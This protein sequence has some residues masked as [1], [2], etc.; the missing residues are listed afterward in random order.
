MARARSRADG[1][2]PATAVARWRAARRDGRAGADHGRAARRALRRWCASP[3][4]APTGSSSRSSSIRRSSRRTR[5]SPPIRAP[6]RPTLRRWPR[7]TSTWSGRRDVAG[8]VSG[9]LCHP[10]RAGGPGRRPGSRMRSGRISS[11]GVATV[12]A[13]LFIQA[14]PD[15]AMFGEKDYQQLKVVTPHGARSRPAARDRRRADRAR[16][17]RPRDVVAQRLPL[18]RPSARPRRCSTAC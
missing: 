1:C 13:K 12:V 16:D 11:G 5:T 9:R 14:T 8:D 3:A 4:A 7:R 17:G 6:S 10:H 2:R 18:A 15:F